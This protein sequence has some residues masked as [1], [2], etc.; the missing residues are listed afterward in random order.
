MHVDRFGWATFE[1]GG[2]EREDVLTKLSR[3]GDW[4]VQLYEFYDDIDLRYALVPN[5]TVIEPLCCCPQVLQA[6]L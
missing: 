2:T 3:T 4:L 6:K 1:H 5:S